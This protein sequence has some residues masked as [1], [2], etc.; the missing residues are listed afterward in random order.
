VDITQ[1]IENKPRTPVWRHGASRIRRWDQCWCGHFEPSEA[2]HRGNFWK[3]SVV[4]KVMNR[5]ASETGSIRKTL[6]GRS[7]G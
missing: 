1:P 5:I 2:W 4:P 7:I 3:S 6:A